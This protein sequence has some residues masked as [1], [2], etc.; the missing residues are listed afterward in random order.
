MPFA[1]VPVS[2][3][4]LAPGRVR[5]S[6]S[7]PQLLP[8][9]AP[10]TARAPPPYTPVA[11]APSETRSSTPD[12]LEQLTGSV[13]RSVSSNLHE[14]SEESA[15]STEALDELLLR[16]GN[17]IREREQGESVI[18]RT[19]SFPFNLRVF[20]ELDLSS[21]SRRTLLENNASLKA[22]NDALIARLPSSKPSSPIS[23]PP[24]TFVSLSSLS[25]TASGTL[26]PS[27][28]GSGW[29]PQPPS[30]ARRR[31]GHSRKPS[32]PAELAALADQN[33]ELL[34]KFQDLESEAARSEQA[35]KRRLRALEREIGT[36][37]EE[38]DKTRALG[39]RLEESLQ[40]QG[41]SANGN[42]EGKSGLPEELEK[43]L[44][45]V[46]K[47]LAREAKV[48]EMRAKARPWEVEES[49]PKDFAP[50]NPLFA[51]ARTSTPGTRPSVANTSSASSARSHDTS[52]PGSQPKELTDVDDPFPSSD[53]AQA[54][55]DSVKQ[56]ALAS[57]TLSPGRERAIVAK[58]LAKIAE[59]EETNTS[60][61]QE[62]QTSQ[63]RL[64]EAER[65]ADGVRALCEIISEE[66]ELEIVDL[67]EGND[68][69]LGHLE[70]ASGDSGIRK[71]E[72]SPRRTIRLR[73]LGRK[74]SLNF[75]STDR[76]RR[77]NEGK[78][79]K[80][81]SMENLAS[82]SEQ[83][84]RGNTPNRFLAQDDD[85][86]PSED[87]RSGLRPRKSIP[88][89][90]RS[91][92]G[93]FDNNL[94]ST[95]FR[96]SDSSS[97]VFGLPGIAEGPA[98][99]DREQANTE[100]AL[101]QIIA[102]RSS[103]DLYDGNLHLG[104]ERRI[105]SLGSELGGEV[106]LGLMPSMT[107]MRSNSIVELL[108]EAEGEPASGSMS[109]PSTLRVRDADLSPTLSRRKAMGTPSCRIPDMS[110]TPRSPG[111]G[112]TSKKFA[113]DD[114]SMR[115]ASLN[116][117]IMFPRLRRARSRV[118]SSQSTSFEN[119][120]LDVFQETQET[121]ES[122]QKTLA[123]SDTSALE[124]PISSDKYQRKQRT[125]S[126]ALLIELWLWL[127][128]AVVIVVFLFAMARMGPRTFFRKSKTVSKKPNGN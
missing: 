120:A 36:L 61:A 73:S 41:G 80:Y 46:W 128:F 15:V 115:S 39:E 9:E 52:E 103:N 78:L 94:S 77:G 106:G 35:G 60:L 75:D 100:F 33:A 105:P 109:P 111:N 25:P 88:K 82:G 113:E 11:T 96:T 59:L 98:S 8:A 127:Q 28:S 20:A 65:E 121:Q 125:K 45:K 13:D 14:F 126:A 90:R 58:L 114:L 62:H 84:T 72:P 51:P 24:Q 76:E 16:A 32:T 54:N 23:S 57:S 95:D 117:E 10:F 44:F 27:P 122:E 29:S 48:K 85:M 47:R 99:P 124:T 116:E 49:E 6:A 42:G 69:E 12:L 63:A 2:P 91:V 74:N 50:S 34:S 97:S 22:R 118:L 31:F 107:H 102:P 7:K 3:R 67:D 53:Q 1:D 64:R 37:K 110:S 26:S 5:R 4:P 43:E 108:N 38:L 123:R 66:V 70:H 87:R 92:R 112:K 83:T 56:H 93:L 86:K 30:S 40:S 81:S 71:T 55:L 79:R 17:I 68:R 19:Y 18:T 21:Q 89:I 104:E 119:Q 101:P